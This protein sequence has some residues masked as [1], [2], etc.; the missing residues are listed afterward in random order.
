MSSRSP[1]GS[2]DT[3]G[4]IANHMGCDPAGICRA[5]HGVAI[6]PSTSRIDQQSLR[7]VPILFQQ[8]PVT[9]EIAVL[10]DRQRRQ[11]R[12]AEDFSSMLAAHMATVMPQFGTADGGKREKLRRT[13]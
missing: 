6:V 11:P 13:K 4:W 9:V 10:W 12:Y 7:L 3:G 8:E 5:G 1:L 2:T